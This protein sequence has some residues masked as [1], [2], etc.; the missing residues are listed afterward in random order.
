MNKKVML[1]LGILLSL[2]LSLKAQNLTLQ[3]DTSEIDNLAE[4]MSLGLGLGQ[5]YGGIGANLLYYMNDNIGLFGGAGHAIA[6]FGYNVG[7]K[8]RFLPKK[9]SGTNFYLLG[10]YGYNAAVKV[11]GADNFNKLFYGPTVGFGIDT[12][13]HPFKSGYWSFALMIP[14]RKAEVNDYMDMLEDDYGVEFDQ[15]MLPIT[16]SVGYRF[17]LD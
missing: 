3:N 4:T 9:Q 12:G 14:F 10:M 1:M 2:S 8:A 11:E 5:D 16:F 17:A 13:K 7:V 15:K 6:G